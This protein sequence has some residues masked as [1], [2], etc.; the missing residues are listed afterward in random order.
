MSLPPSYFDHLYAASH[1]PWGFRTR[2][3]EERKR[4]LTVAALLRPRYGRVFEPGCSIGTL[5]AGLAA[6]AEQVVA[7]DPAADALAQAAA[8]VPDHVDLVRGAVPADWPAGPFDLV[9]LSEVAY[10]LDRPA[11]EVLGDRA[12]G[13]AA[14]VIAVHW[15]HPVDDYPLGGDD[16]HAALGEAAADAGLIRLVAHVEEDFLL[17][18]WARDPRSVAARQGLLG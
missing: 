3:Y 13:C 4:A 2:P 14:E 18:V 16:V 1:D 10:Y 6:R 7:M 17:D 11:L 12:M 9:V 5:T 15:R 8:A